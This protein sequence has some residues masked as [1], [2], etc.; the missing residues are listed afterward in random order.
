MGILRELL[1]EEVK[2]LIR[3]H[4][5][6]NP[7]DIA[8]AENIMIFREPLGEING[9]YN[10]YVRQKMIHINSNLDES[11]F[12]GLF[13]CSHELCHAKVHPN[14]NTPFL[15]DST[16]FSVDKLE[17]QANTFAAFMIIPKDILLHY[18]G[19]TL[20]QIAYAE[21]IPVQALKLRFNWM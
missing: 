9:Y 11:S 12:K 18:E 2:K 13:T 10:K 19:F 4:K 3:K 1:E 16:L 15:R 7:F 17:V 8:R 21:G 5:T 14:S 6:N 20:Q